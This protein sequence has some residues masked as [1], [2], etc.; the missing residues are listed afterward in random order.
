MEDQA[1]VSDAMSDEVGQCCIG[2][3]CSDCD[4]PCASAGEGATVIYR[5][6]CRGYSR[7][8]VSD[9]GDVNASYRWLSLPT[10][11]DEWTEETMRDVFQG[12]R[13]REFVL[14]GSEEL[15]CRTEEIS[16]EGEQFRSGLRT[17]RARAV[18]EALKNSRF[19]KLFSMAQ[20]LNEG[21]REAYLNELADYQETDLLT[22]ELFTLL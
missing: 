8:T 22:R 16:P 4:C 21:D 12:I 6:V 18:P 1:I 17:L 2:C 5:G 14:F 13:V 3:A 11:Q 15:E 19:G 20:K 10:K 7:D 9:N